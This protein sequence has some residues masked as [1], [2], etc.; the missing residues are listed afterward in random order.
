ME[1]NVV[2]RDQL[3]GIAVVRYNRRNLYIE[4]ANAL[5]VQQ[6]DQAVVKPGDQDQDTR[7]ATGLMNGPIHIVARTNF[8]EAR[9]QLRRLAG[10]AVNAEMNTHTK[11]I[12]GGVA[13]LRAIDYV[14]A[15]MHHESANV[16]NNPWAIWTGQRQNILSGS[17]RREYSNP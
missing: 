14:A 3:T 10:L 12:G 1:R 13:K 4:L 2:R 8:R 9:A 16:V 6:V 11:E 15:A 7:L 17:G 5:P